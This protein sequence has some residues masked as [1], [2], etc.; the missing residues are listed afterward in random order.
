MA[1]SL[2]LLA[3]AIGLMALIGSSPDSMLPLGLDQMYGEENLENDASRLKVY[4]CDLG[5][6]F[7]GNNRFIWGVGYGSAMRG[8]CS[9]DDV[10][11]NLSHS[12]N[13]VLQIWAETG[14]V[15]TLFLVLAS[16]WILLR[17]LKTLGMA[18]RSPAALLAA[19]FHSLPTGE[20]T[21]T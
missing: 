17:V 5:L 20:E 3:L 8:M 2:L 21:K 11:R 18:D 1:A 12:H 19:P 13:L 16:G 7:T 9:A 14:L 15:A 4:S 6:P 10:G